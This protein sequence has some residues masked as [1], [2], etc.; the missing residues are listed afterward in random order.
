[1]FVSLFYRLEVQHISEAGFMA[2]EKKPVFVFAPEKFEPELM[3]KMF[4]GVFEYL[5][6]IEMEL[7]KIQ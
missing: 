7:K 5:E 4:D 3:Y 6:D 1:M 2:G